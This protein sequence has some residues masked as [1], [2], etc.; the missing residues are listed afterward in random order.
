MNEPYFKPATAAG[1]AGDSPVSATQRDARTLPVISARTGAALRQRRRRL[2][3][4]RFNLEDT[5]FRLFRV[6]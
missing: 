3:V 6:H 2:S 4:P 5:G 1:L